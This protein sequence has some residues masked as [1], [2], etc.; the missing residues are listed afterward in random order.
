MDFGLKCVLMRVGVSRPRP[1]RV[2]SPPGKVSQQFPDRYVVY[3][4]NE[5][6]K[7][8]MLVKREYMFTFLK[9]E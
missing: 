2:S 6:S 5:H 8:R 3:N 7:Q 4:C 9:S 1:F